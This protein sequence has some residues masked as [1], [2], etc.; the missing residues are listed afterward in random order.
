MGTVIKVENFKT[1]GF[2]DIKTEA[3]RGSEGR[4]LNEAVKADRNWEGVKFH[5]NFTLS[6]YYCK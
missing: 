5:I 1:T 6:V 4:I 2:L 3:G